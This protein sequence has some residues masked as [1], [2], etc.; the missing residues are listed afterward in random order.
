M[1]LS[2][3]LLLEHIVVQWALVCL[4]SSQNCVLADMANG[5]HEPLRDG[6]GSEDWVK[7]AGFAKRA[8]SPPLTSSARAGFV[9][10]VLRRSKGATS[11]STL[12]TK[13]S[14]GLLFCVFSFMLA[15]WRKHL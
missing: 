15:T 14:W 4:C 12:Q 5:R 1:R 7:L 11:H 9:R 10:S 13:L 6:S 3:A 8:S 2:T